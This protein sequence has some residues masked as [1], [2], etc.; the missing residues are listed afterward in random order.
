D[1][2]WLQSLTYVEVGPDGE[3]I[4]KQKYRDAWEYAVRSEVVRDPLLAKIRDNVTLTADEEE[5]L[6]AQLNQA[7]HY[8]NEENLRRAYKYQ[9]GTL[10]DF[11]RVA[12]GTRK[13]K[14]DA[15][16]LTDNFNA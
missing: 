6:A 8:F 4:D 15:E 9:G 13:L 7:A 12:L 3:R 10:I 16:I 5:R 11:I 2:E 1:D 14:T